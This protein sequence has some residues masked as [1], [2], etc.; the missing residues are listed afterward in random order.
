[1]TDQQALADELAELY[2]SIKEPIQKGNILGLIDDL[3]YRVAWLARSAEL[4]ADAQYHADK[5]AGDIASRSDPGMAWSAV[6]AIV[7]G[8]SADQTRLLKLA[9]KLNST[10][11]HQIESIRSI[12]SFEKQSAMQNRYEGK[13]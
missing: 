11:I 13:A 4:V 2:S 12:L 7:A 9:E 3:S 8:E 1:M 5:I 6:K 10:L